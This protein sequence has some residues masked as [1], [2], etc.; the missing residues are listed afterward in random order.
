MSRF[1]IFFGETWHLFHTKK[2]DGSDG[3][4]FFAK[5]TLL[6]HVNYLTFSSQGLRCVSS[7]SSQSF[8]CGWRIQGKG[9]STMQRTISMF[10]QLQKF[11]NL[12]LIFKG[13][14]NIKIVTKSQVKYLQFLHC[15]LYSEWIQWIFKLVLPAFWRF[16]MYLAE[17][18]LFQKY[19]LRIWPSFLKAWRWCR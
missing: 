10:R 18:W 13:K 12:I 6:S 3:G 2:L 1:W 7:T 5:K 9:D 17:E 14:H 11:H 8:L 15:L 16:W 4:F 19:P